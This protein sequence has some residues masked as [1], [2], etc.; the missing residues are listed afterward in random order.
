MVV[1]LVV[2]I[3]RKVAQS[4]WDCSLTKKKRKK[5]SHCN[6]GALFTREAPTKNSFFTN[7]KHPKIQTLIKNFRIFFIEFH[8]VEKPKR[9]PLRFAK[10]F[11]QSEYFSKSERVPFDQKMS[12]KS[13]Y[14]RNSRPF[15]QILRKFSSVPQD[16]KI[17]K[18]DR[19]STDKKKAFNRKPQKLKSV[20]VPQYTKISKED[21]LSTDKKKAFNRKPQKLKSVKVSK[22]SSEKRIVPKNLK[23]KKRNG[24]DKKVA[25]PKQ[26]P[27]G[28]NHCKHR[29][30]GLVRVWKVALISNK[31]AGPLP[32]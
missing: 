4:E 29:E 28:L 23:V 31:K 9:G 18:E 7:S 10:R 14:W 12:T 13:Q 6:S 1:V 5:T 2:S 21:R 11:I 25:V 30:F 8:K 27:K 17:S 19:L 16:T 24:F 15:P 22:K 3:V 26:N 32:C 20:K